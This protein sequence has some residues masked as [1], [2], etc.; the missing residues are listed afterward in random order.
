MISVS[1]HRAS[2]AITTAI[3]LHTKVNVRCYI[4]KQMIRITENAEKNAIIKRR[5]EYGIIAGS[6]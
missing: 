1:F 5:H 3:R 2:A 6:N 4:Q